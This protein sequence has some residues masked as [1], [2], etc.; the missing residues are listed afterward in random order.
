M[1]LTEGTLG[2][3]KAKHIKRSHVRVD[4]ELASRL[5]KPQGDYFTVESRAVPENRR[6]RFA[7]IA[8]ELSDCLRQATAGARSTAGLSGDVKTVLV[9]GLGNPSL[10]A[11]ALGN[12]VGKRLTVTRHIDAARIKLC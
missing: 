8:A 5:N 10:T 9:V 2:K 3:A 1:E 7:D 12:C 4:E 6:D 11:D